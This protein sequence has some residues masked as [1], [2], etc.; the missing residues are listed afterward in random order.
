MVIVGLFINPVD[1]L[2]LLIYFVIY[3]LVEDNAL[4]PVIYSR[5][6]QLHPLAIFVAILV[7]GALLGIL[8]A[9]LAIPIA[10]I[11]CIIGTDWLATRRAQ[12]RKERESP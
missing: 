11:I 7:G 4:T 9:L 2:V 10:E 3:K 1:S 8:G 12:R 5:S 6:V